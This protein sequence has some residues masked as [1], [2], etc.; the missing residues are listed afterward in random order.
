MY[1][2]YLEKT[3]GLQCSVLKVFVLNF[4]SIMQ[5]RNRLRAVL[6]SEFTSIFKDVKKQKKT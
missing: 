2:V 1:T 4:V 5:Y 3:I 6:A